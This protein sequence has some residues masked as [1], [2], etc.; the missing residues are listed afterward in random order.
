[1]K[2]NIKIIIMV[3]MLVFVVAGAVAGYSLLKNNVD[4]TTVQADTSSQQTAKFTDFNFFDIDNNEVKLSSFSGKAIVLNFWA[5]WCPPCAGE[6]PEF[7]SAYNDY[8]DDVQFIMLNLTDGEKETE[9]SVKD[10]IAENGYTFPVYMD[11]KAEGAKTYGIYTIPQ[12]IFIDNQGNIIYTHTG[13][14]TLEQLESYI[15]QISE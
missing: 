11:K 10:F 7:Q 1:M 2:S 8:K 3:S 12:T 15:K 13:A 4:N 6:L 14:I 9:E 5:T